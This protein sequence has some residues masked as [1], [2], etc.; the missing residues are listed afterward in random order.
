MRVAIWLCGLA[1]PAT[2]W[3][4]ESLVLP[5]AALGRW[6]PTLEQCAVPFGESRGG[7]STEDNMNLT[8]EEIEFWESAG[9]YRVMNIEDRTFALLLRMTGEGQSWTEHQVLVLSEDG[10]QLT[11]RSGSIEV[12]YL[13]CGE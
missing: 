8:P 9:Q 2:L 10:Q 7:I 12:D 1:L 13:R 6:S 4:G 3:A 11:R 5:Q